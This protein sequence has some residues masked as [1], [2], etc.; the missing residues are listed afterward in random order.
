MK[1]FLLI[2][3]TCLYDEHYFSLLLLKQGF[4]NILANQAYPTRGTSTDFMLSLIDYDAFHEKEMTVCFITWP[5]HI[6]DKKVL[7]EV[8]G[9]LP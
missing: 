7:K 1:V 5:F 2:A 4:Q 9:K 8:L 3:F 6:L